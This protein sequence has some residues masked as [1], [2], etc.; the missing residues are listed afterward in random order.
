MYFC[1]PKTIFSVYTESR[2]KK[3]RNVLTYNSLRLNL[4]VISVSAK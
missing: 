4:S 2:R 1:L 3:N